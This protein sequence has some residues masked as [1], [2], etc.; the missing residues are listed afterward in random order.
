MLNAKKGLYCAR[1]VGHMAAL[2]I[3]D[4]KLALLWKNDKL[5]RLLKKGGVG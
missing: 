4:A 5:L 1:K 3:H 2:T